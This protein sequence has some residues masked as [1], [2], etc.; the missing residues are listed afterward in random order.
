MIDLNPSFLGNSPLIRCNLCD[1]PHYKD[2]TT[3]GADAER[4][5]LPFGKCKFESNCCILVRI[6]VGD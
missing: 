4:P 3:I 6:P 5:I 2:F 1:E